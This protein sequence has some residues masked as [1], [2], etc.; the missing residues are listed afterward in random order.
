VSDPVPD[1]ADY[2]AISAHERIAKFYKFRTPYGV[3]FFDKFARNAGLG[4]ESD[5]LDLC[6][7]T[8]AIA[9]GLAPHCRSIDAIDGAPTMIA[10]APAFERVAYHILDI[11]SAAFTNWSR[12]RTFDLISI[13]MGVHWL[14]DAVLEI[15]RNCL[16]PE[17]YIAILATGF[18]G[19]NLNPWF[20]DYNAVRSALTPRKFRDWTGEARLSAMGYRKTDYIEQV[21]RAQVPV[22]FLIR[23]MLS[24]SAEASK[25]ASSY[26]AVLAEMERKLEAHIRDGKL[27][28][29]WVSSARLFVDQK[30]TATPLSTQSP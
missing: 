11:N 5:V 18:A 23:N 27:E 8:G 6:C 24:F 1:N 13:G 28:C 16:R 14:D 22:D 26:A 7:G 2:D 20:G 9:A 17:G 3:S 30:S 4:P 10:L 15:L 21:Y 19:Q 12:A 25:V 29:F